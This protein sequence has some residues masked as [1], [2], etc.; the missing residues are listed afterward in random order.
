MAM[1]AASVVVLL[2]EGG[3][4]M[5]I[6]PLF[7][8]TCPR[9][10]DLTGTGRAFCLRWSRGRITV[11]RARGMTGGGLT[12]VALTVGLAALSV[13]AW[14][15]TADDLAKQYKI[16][17]MEQALQTKEHYD[18]YGLRFDSDQSTIPGCENRSSTTLRQRSKAFPNG[19]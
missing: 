3:I 7:N 12:A 18:L 15:Q 16:E 14:A 4:E 2:M 9:R 6:Y 1:G 10:G 11:G 5:S 17:N 19:I 13:P 8:P